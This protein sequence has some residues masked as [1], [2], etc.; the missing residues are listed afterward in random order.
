MNRQEPTDNEILLDQMIESIIHF[1]GIF[2]LVL[3]AYGF[4]AEFSG[5]TFEPIESTVD[6]ISTISTLVGVI[7]SACSVY[8]PPLNRPAEIRSKKVIAPIVLIMIVLA[9][10]Y[11][12]VTKKNLPVSVVLG[13]ANL[14][15]A[16]TLF[17]TISLGRHTKWNQK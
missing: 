5:D 10:I 1:V 6:L 3:I 9:I 2:G 16:G 7:L 11:M 13:F 12:P 4:T 15:L 17:R 14:G 8:F